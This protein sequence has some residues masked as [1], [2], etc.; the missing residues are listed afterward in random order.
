MPLD[1]SSARNIRLLPA[2]TVA[3]QS[4]PYG[5]AGLRWWKEMGVV[6]PRQLEVQRIHLDHFT[7]HPR[8]IRLPNGETLLFYVAGP[9][10]YAWAKNK[11]L[12]NE[13][14]LRRSVDGWN[15]QPAEKPWS[16]PYS[17][18]APVPFL[19]SGSKTL[20]AF[21]T[22]PHPEFYDG[23]ENAAI[24][25]RESTDYGRTW[26]KVRIIAPQNAPDFRGMSAMR[27][28]ETA[29][30]AWLL[31]SHSG[32]WSGEEGVD[33]KVVTN[34]YLLRS[35]DRGETWRL[36]PGWPTGWQAPGTDRMDEGRPIHLGA[37]G[38][39][40]MV[41]TPKGFLYQLR[42]LDGGV[43][44]SAPEPTSLRH[45]DAPPMLFHLDERTL[46]AFHHNRQ[47]KGAFAHESRAELWLSLSTDGARTWTEP[48]FVM[49]NACEAALLN[50]WGGF[51]PMVSYADL[52]TDGEWLHLFVD[53][54][55]R[56]VIQARFRRQDIESLPTR[57][58]I[59]LQTAA[60]S[61]SLAPA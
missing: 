51:T 17:Q 49:A 39:L 45:P 27:L 7:C 55:M 56:Q 5:A 31:G 28:S 11:Q 24:G 18:H 38:E 16:I 54:Q 33:R 52:V 57:E 53:H 48:R 10:H 42:S 20:Y 40:M 22:E 21:G 12:G 3:D 61:R 58:D 30:G 41:R 29:D 1:Q 44:W 9:M 36:Q 50:G 34:Q 14:Y 13:V 37:D 35:D 6:T 46:I 19:P 60:A 59:I 43:T 23:E 26:S 25:F 47:V 32:T 15:W 2:V 8:A 4:I